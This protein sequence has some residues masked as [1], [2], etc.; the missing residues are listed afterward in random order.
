MVQIGKLLL[1]VTQ[2]RTPEESSADLGDLTLP[3]PEEV[4]VEG[5]R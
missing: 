1:K 4:K 5:V 2:A 3:D